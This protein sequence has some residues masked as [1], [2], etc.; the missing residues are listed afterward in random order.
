MRGQYDVGNGL[1]AEAE[2]ELDM[3]VAVELAQVREYIRSDLTGGTLVAQFTVAEQ[4]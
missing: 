4:G 1:F 2:L 3:A